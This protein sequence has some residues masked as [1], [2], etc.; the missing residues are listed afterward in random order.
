MLSRALKKCFSDVNQ[1]CFRT[2]VKSAVENP[3][4]NKAY[5]IRYKVLCNLYKPHCNGYRSLC[6]Y[7]GYFILC[8]TC[9]YAVSCERGSV[10]DY[11]MREGLGVC[12]VSFRRR[13]VENYCMR[14]DFGFCAVISGQKRSDP[15]F[16]LRGFLQF[17][18]V[19][20]LRNIRLTCEIM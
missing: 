6:M 7:E 8:E 10:G 16:I 20:R 2:N 1:R 17:A 12:E 5:C 11:C 4:K 9:F 18:V 13:N 15:Y 19:F 14:E 3:S